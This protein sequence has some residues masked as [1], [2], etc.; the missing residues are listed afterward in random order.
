MAAFLSP[1]AVI[2]LSVALILGYVPAAAAAA[3]YSCVFVLADSNR[4]G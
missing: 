2:P 1:Y 4:L 3:W